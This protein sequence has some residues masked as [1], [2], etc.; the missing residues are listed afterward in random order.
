VKNGC[1]ALAIRGIGEEYNGGSGK[2]RP[3]A[4]GAA[5]RPLYGGQINFHTC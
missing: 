1:V 4:M 2:T 5:L 3:E